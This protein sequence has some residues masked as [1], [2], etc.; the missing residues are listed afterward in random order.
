MK[1]SKSEIRSLTRVI[2]REAR[3]Q[4]DKLYNE[5]AN[6]AKIEQIA[7]AD[8]DHIQQLSPVVRE[9]VM[10]DFPDVASIC[11]T[12]AKNEWKSKARD[13]KRDGVIEDEIILKAS[14]AVDIDDLKAMIDPFVTKT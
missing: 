12:I 9:S 13:V 6:S 11:D 1:L 7:R 8:M 2:V 5:I 3:E 14:K 4:N 10:Q